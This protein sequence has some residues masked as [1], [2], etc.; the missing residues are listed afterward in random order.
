MAKKSHSLIL[1]ATLLFILLIV[2]LITVVIAYS[3]LSYSN[4]YDS[5]I[6]LMNSS[7]L[8]ILTHCDTILSD[9]TNTLSEF[10]AAS[11]DELYTYNN[12]SQTQQQL[13]Q[14]V[15]QSRLNEKLSY[16]NVADF[17]FLCHSG[18]YP[19]QIAY[20]ER[21]SSK[22]RLQIIDFFA[23]N[24]KFENDTLSDKWHL[25]QINDTWYLVQ[26][27]MVYG[28][29]IGG[30]I[31]LSSL[32]IS[33][34]DNIKYT[35][36]DSHGTV[37]Y[38]YGDDF[39]S[40]ANDLVVS[41]T[42][43]SIEFSLSKRKADVLTNLKNRFFVTVSLGV[44]SILGTLLISTFFREKILKPVKGLIHG[45]NELKNG[46]FDYEVKVP[47][48]AGELGDLTV[49]FNDMTR[50]IKKLN[51]MEIERQNNELR[52]LKMQIR[53]HFYL[54]AITTMASFSHQNE[55]AKLQLFSISLS[56]YLRYLL[57]NERE[58]STIGLEITQSSAF[59]ELYKLKDPNHIY[60]LA[61][62][63]PNLDS[64]VI[65]R[66]LILTAVENAM[67][68]ARTKDSFFTLIVS[69]QNTDDFI[70]IAIEDNGSG[71]P[72]EYLSNPSSSAND[73]AERIGLS[74]IRKIL[75][76]RYEGKAKMI[77]ENIQSGGARVT[78][79]IPKGEKNYASI[80][81]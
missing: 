5:T 32:F 22:E 76:L 43:A 81:S 2:L 49:A 3:I 78:Y 23:S 53:P 26:S 13:L 4:I 38:T 39:E 8:L 24:P 42:L 77:L 79:Y 30:A 64:V 18:T 60:F 37:L 66:F 31:K 52:F 36:K 46:N 51:E 73:H 1:S 57:E 12:H 58:E 55:D 16:S 61:A 29:S 35:L 45:T 20:S 14:L 11:M 7:L 70:K 65:P 15:W 54:N 47:C 9:I 74:N 62:T 17:L 50:R 80:D 69:T 27:Y 19:V 75:S 41:S 28:S 10:G 33:Q 67:K 68:H 48:N 63:D 72:E 44:I 59:V 25:L 40:K 34:M 21:T 71:F 6:D 56:K